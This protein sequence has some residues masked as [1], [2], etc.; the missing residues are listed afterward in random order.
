MGIIVGAV[1]G[2]ICGQGT[3]AVTE[4]HWVASMVTGAAAATGVIIWDLITYRPK[5]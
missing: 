3:Y 1:S 5:R 2:F 4:S